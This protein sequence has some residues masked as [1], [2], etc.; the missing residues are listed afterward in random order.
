TAPGAEICTL[1]VKDHNWGILALGHIDPVLRIG[2]HPA[3]QPES[4]AGG[5]F[6]KIADQL[7]GIVT[8][9]DLC[10][11]RSPPENESATPLRLLPQ[12]NIVLRHVRKGLR[13]PRNALRPYGVHYLDGGALP[14]LCKLRGG[15]DANEV[16]GSCGRG[17]S[18]GGHVERRASAISLCT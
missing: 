9:A 8:R 17:C 5:Q 2:R 15:S 1:A 6:E 4:L 13:H 18:G 10:H 3:N 7:V 14:L 11:C 12:Q 16:Q